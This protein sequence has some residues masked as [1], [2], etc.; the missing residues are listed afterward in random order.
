MES[1]RGVIRVGLAAYCNL[2]YSALA[3]FRMGMSGSAS[4]AQKALGA[5]TACLLY[6]TPLRAQMSPPSVLK[7]SN[8]THLPSGDHT[9]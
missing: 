7:R 4:S 2:A 6:S 5:S 3:C 9:G 1:I 8:R